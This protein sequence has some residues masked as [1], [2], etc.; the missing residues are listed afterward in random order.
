MQ[1][2]K[3]NTQRQGNAD[4]DWVA[5]DGTT[6]V[7]GVQLGYGDVAKANFP[8]LIAKTQRYLTRWGNRN[9][10]ITGRALIANSI[11]LSRVWFHCRFIFMPSTYRRMLNS[12][13][14]KFLHPKNKF[15]PIPH[16]TTCAPMG[17]DAVGLG[18][19]DVDRNVRATLC[20]ALVNW[21][22]PMPSPWKDVTHQLSAL[23]DWYKPQPTEN[24][25]AMQ[26]LLDTAAPF[27][28]KVSEFWYQAFA[29]WRKLRPS[30]TAPSTF[31]ELLAMPLWNNTIFLSGDGKQLHLPQWRL[32]GI[33]YVHQL[34]GEGRWLT[35]AELLERK[36]GATQESTIWRCHVHLTACKGDGGH[37][38]SHT[39]QLA[40]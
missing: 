9:L 34:W 20:Q 11:G 29:A 4:L 8:A 13:I 35:P 38:P 17:S 7:L 33:N 5:E 22:A 18:L 32:A 12:M 3:W 39:R 2:P 1:N 19:I 27:S 24:Y 28:R 14:N 26:R 31:E 40:H 37:R 21:T 10:S 30:I 23:A 25:T 36:E 16:A 6:R 15:S